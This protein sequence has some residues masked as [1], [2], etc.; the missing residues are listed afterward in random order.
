MKHER[1]KQCTK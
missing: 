1:R